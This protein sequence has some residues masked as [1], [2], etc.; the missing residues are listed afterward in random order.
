MAGKAEETLDEFIE[1]MYSRSGT[2]DLP[3]HLDARYGIQVARLTEL[4]LG[5]F[6]VDRRDGPS[7]LA[8]V[9]PAARPIE[10]AESDAGILRFL[11]QRGFPAE[12]CAHPSPVSVHQGQ[13]VLV[14]EYAQGTRAAGSEQTFHEL[15]HLLGR[16]HTLPP[17]AGAM[18]RDG[19]AWHHVSWS[20][21]PRAEIRA[22][23]ALLAAAEHRVPAPQRALHEALRGELERA[24]DGLDLPAALIHPDFVPTNAIA[25]PDGAVVVVD[26][27]GAGR[28]P[29]ISSLGFL[30]WAAGGRDLTRVDAVMA[31]YRE[32]IRLE[33]GE[34]ARLGGAV[35][36]RPLVL[37][38]WA[39]CMGRKALSDVVREW[40]ASRDLAEAIAARARE[41][42]EHRAGPAAARG[43]QPGVPGSGG[44]PLE[45]VGGT[46]LAVAAIRAAETA[47]PDRLFAD[48]LAGAFVAASGWSSARPPGDRRA[49]ALKTWVVARTVFLDELLVSAGQDGCRQVVL[50]GA[51]FDARAFRLP[52]PPGVRCFELDTADV[53]DRKAQVLTAE[54]AVAGCERIPVAC[55]LRADW[56]AALL[57]AGLRPGQ[58]TAWIA[59]GLL[60][61]LGG[62]EVDRLLAALTSLSAPGSRIGLTMPNR[63]PGAAGGL[64]Q[65]PG[66]MALRRSTAPDDPVGWLAGHG[67]AAQVTDAIEVLRAHGRPVPARP[68]DQ[69]PRRPRAILVSAA[70]VRDGRVMVEDPG[71]TLPHYPMVSHRGGFPDGS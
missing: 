6:R 35:R 29:R 42:V 69:G 17:A 7:W 65:G 31:G 63:D 38:C 25:A 4:D 3:S 58:R 5:V 66:A 20:G 50:L 33:P 28:G 30:L 39:F 43:A 45:G 36:A 10:A 51:G 1:R 70:R 62:Y 60:T 15:G 48:P 14:T 46:G 44:P 13:A 54:Q 32:H 57:A 67:W 26:W 59:E 49:A 40:P 52:W 56:S 64:G 8:R 19:G 11:D 68:A 41:A 61:Y 9:F 71:G 55:D 16:L 2:E 24:E 34:L 12:R 23:M 18:A 22:A 21:G 27:T 47:R 53:L 37:E